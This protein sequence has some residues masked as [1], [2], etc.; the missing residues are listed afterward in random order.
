ML[1]R[2]VVCLTIANMVAASG[3][4]LAAWQVSAV[5]EALA[6][7]SAD[8]RKSEEIAGATNHV[9]EDVTRLAA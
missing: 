8:V 5:G 4:L 1:T 7:N 2:F 3:V 9:R 6:W